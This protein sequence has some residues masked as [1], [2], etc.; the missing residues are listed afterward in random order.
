MA[1]LIPWL[2]TGWDTGSIWPPLR[3]IGGVLVLAGAVFLLT[4]FARF[5]LEGLGTPAPVAPT[6]HLVV[7]GEY[8]HVRNPM[9]VAVTATI[10]GQAFL[11]GR[12]E[13]LPYA[14][15][16]WLVVAS[17]VKLYEEPTLAA[18]YGAAYEEYRNAV[19]AWL[20]RVRPWRP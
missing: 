6:E 18:R 10:V 1:G 3:V 20:P 11:L 16:F 15:A 12:L 14:A 2:I 13:L 19:P 7:H 17:F 4:S 8:R 5:V 9:Y